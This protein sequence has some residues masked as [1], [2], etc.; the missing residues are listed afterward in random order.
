VK[1]ISTVAAEAITQARTNVVEPIQGQV[2]LNH[3]GGPQVQ[4]QV[5]NRS[6]P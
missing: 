4:D 1:T 5:Q 3:I 6:R 2:A